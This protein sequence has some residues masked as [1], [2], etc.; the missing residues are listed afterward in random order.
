MEIWSKFTEE[1]VQNVLSKKSFEFAVEINELTKRIDFSNSL[2]FD[3]QKKYLKN[4]YRSTVSPDRIE[5]SPK[6]VNKAFN[7]AL[8]NC[9][10]CLEFSQQLVSP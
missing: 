2:I 9:F 8:F 5:K 4:I 1:N 10:S 6:A 3:L 7:E